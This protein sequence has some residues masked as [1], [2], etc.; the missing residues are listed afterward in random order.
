MELRPAIPKLGTEK[1]LYVNQGF[2]VYLNWNSFLDF[3][4]RRAA[5]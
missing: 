3:L 2:F 5:L 4:L 1:P